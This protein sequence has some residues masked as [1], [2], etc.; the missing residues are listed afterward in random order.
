M[1]GDGGGVKGNQALS[2]LVCIG[3]CSNMWHA[4]QMYNIVRVRE[5]DACMRI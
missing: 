4:P 5:V 3:E 1:H 2:D